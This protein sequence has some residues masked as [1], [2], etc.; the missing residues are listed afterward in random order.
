VPFNWLKQLSI[1][2]IR[3]LVL[4]LL[5]ATWA[6]VGALL[7]WESLTPAFWMAGAGFSLLAAV[8]AGILAGWVRDQRLL[9][10]RLSEHEARAQDVERRLSSVI[11]LNSQL[12][13]AEDEQGLVETALNVVSNLTG[14]LA[15]SFVPLDELGEPLSAIVHGS[16]PQPIL[17][18]WA[19]HLASQLVRKTCGKCQELHADAGQVC[20]LLQG[21][22]ADAFSV[23]CLPMTRGQRAYGLLNIYFGPHTELSPETRNFLEG[24]LVEMGNAI[25]VLRLR[26][27]EL[28]TVRQLQLARANR[29]GL[30]TALELVLE[31]LRT[32]FEMDG[33]WLRADPLREHQGEIEVRQGSTEWIGRGKSQ[34]LYERVLRRPGEV[35]SIELDEGGSIRA[36]SLA[37]G[38]TGATG[39]LLLFSA[40]TR[41]PVP[42]EMAVLK[43]VASQAALLIESERSRESLEF[44]IVMQERTRLA[45][46]IHD[47][48]AQTLAYL[49]LQTAHMQRALAQNDLT[50]LKN[51]LGQNYMALGDAY[52]DVRQAID[53]LRLNPQLGMAHWLDL[54]AK[55]FE[56]TGG[57]PV[58]RSFAELTVEVPSEV[59]AQLVRIV[60]EVFSNIRKHAHAKNAWIMLKEW[61][62]DLILEVGDDGEGFCEEDV[63]VL[64]QYG[65]RGMRERSELIGAD[66]Q[67]VSRPNE[68]TVVHLRL[69][70][71]SWEM[72]K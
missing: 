29:A 66:F 25:Q 4:C 32:S 39:A 44:A 31:N 21:P 63:P 55:E 59:Q 22:F 5:A 72:L 71:R 40:Q 19:E 51:L 37:L 2:W 65:L 10:Q 20:P 17:K 58:R 61:E 62:G 57:I 38:E 26:G 9:E 13:E 15:S 18:A 49:K 35:S 48:L 54:A 52:L 47:G 28:A 67:I 11:H 6:G 27:Q 53:N 60:Q 50:G 7:G 12:M 70:A 41:A 36:A 33:A 3:G 8:F 42:H 1:A 56:H 24:L 23:Y 30:T 14:A 69:P 34:A 46:E 64:S 45:R 16:L 43:T 68:G